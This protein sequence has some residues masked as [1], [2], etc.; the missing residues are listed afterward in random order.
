MPLPSSS[1]TTRVFYPAAATVA[2]TTVLLRSRDFSNTGSP[3][4]GITIALSEVVSRV[5]EIGH[6]ALTVG[7]RGLSLLLRVALAPPQLVSATLASEFHVAAGA[8]AQLGSVLH[9]ASA[10]FLNAL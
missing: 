6:W 2:I 1:G 10:Y 7:E 8:I 5:P 4:S 9:A 3:G